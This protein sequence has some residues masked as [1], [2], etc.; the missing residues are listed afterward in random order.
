MAWGCSD[1]VGWQEQGDISP[2]C[3]LGSYM[4]GPE[5]AQHP[6]WQSLQRKIAQDLGGGGL[7]LS[8]GGGEGLGGGG[9]GLSGGGGD[10]LG[11]GGDGLSGGGRGEGGRGE[12]GAGG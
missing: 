12:G 8:G 2:P 7:G 9:E 11:G 6:T 10:G 3:L 4:L 1:R 5:H